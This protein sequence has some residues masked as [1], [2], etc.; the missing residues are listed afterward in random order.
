MN[1]YTIRNAFEHRSIFAVVHTRIHV[2]IPIVFLCGWATI[3]LIM[4]RR[5]CKLKTRAG[6]SEFPVIIFDVGEPW[7]NNPCIFNTPFVFSA[8]RPVLRRCFQPARLGQLA[9]SAASGGRVE[10]I[11]V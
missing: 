4:W 8:Y 3:K 6:R 1:K 7:A 10:Y 2:V 9:M 5:T 11:A